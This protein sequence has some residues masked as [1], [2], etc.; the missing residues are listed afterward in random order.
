[1]KDDQL[2]IICSLVYLLIVEFNDEDVY[3]LIVEFNDNDENEAKHNNSCGNALDDFDLSWAWWLR[4]AGTLFT[5]VVF[6]V[7]MCGCLLF[8]VS[9]DFCPSRVLHL[10]YCCMLFPALTFIFFLIWIGL[11]TYMV[12]QLYKADSNRSKH[13]KLGRNTTVY[14]GLMYCYLFSLLILTLIYVIYKMAFKFG[15]R[16]RKK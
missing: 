3:L 11:G 6:A 8:T 14:L 4:V 10:M 1:M 2:L 5:V 13:C 9:I 16:R 7:I 12:E 15:Q